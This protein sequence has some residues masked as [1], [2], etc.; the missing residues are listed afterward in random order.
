MDFAVT[1]QQVTTVLLTITMD[2]IIAIAM[3]N[4]VGLNATC[5]AGGAPRYNSSSLK[6]GKLLQL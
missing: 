4:V 3:T 1:N 6:Y 5:R 2:F